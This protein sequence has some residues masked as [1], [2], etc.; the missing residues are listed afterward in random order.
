MYV[1]GDI[2][3][4]YDAP[5]HSGHKT[6]TTTTEH[7]YIVRDDGILGGELIVTGTRTLVRAIFMVG[8]AFPLGPRSH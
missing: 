3:S 1:I 6:M 8:L 4:Q 7:W 5:V 2:D